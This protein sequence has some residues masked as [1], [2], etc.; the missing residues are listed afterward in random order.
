MNHFLKLATRKLRNHYW[1]VRIREDTLIAGIPP[2][3][4]PLYRIGEPFI[5]EDGKLRPAPIREALQDAWIQAEDAPE[6]GL[7]DLVRIHQ[8]RLGKLPKTEQPSL[9]LEAY[10][11]GFELIIEH[12]QTHQAWEYRCHAGET[13]LK[14]WRHVSNWTQAVPLKAFF[15]HNSPLLEEGAEVCLPSMMQEIGPRGEKLRYPTT[16]EPVQG[17]VLNIYA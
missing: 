10:R 9:D 16:L 4:A 15:Q 7:Q 3:T 17:T 8:D 14:M 6:T 2:F 5:H 13:W 12:A 1:T 11:G